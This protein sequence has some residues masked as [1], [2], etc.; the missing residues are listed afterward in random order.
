MVQKVGGCACPPKGRTDAGSA[1]GKWE[2]AR[3]K[4]FLTSHCELQ[5]PRLL[6]SSS[7]RKALYL[8]GN[9]G[10][11][12]WELTH[13]HHILGE[14]KTTTN[15]K[16]PHVSVFVWMQNWLVVIKALKNIRNTQHM[17][18][19]RRL[20]HTLRERKWEQ[21][22]N[23]WNKREGR[24]TLWMVKQC[25]FVLGWVARRLRRMRSLKVNIT[26]KAMSID[27]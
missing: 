6:I 18:P 23:I 7:K 25:H 15:Q 20:S 12:V 3:V 13:G 10:K 14:C 22:R 17:L 5:S 4:G 27:L 9:M 11:Q 24:L 21:G 26:L 8:H 19:S 16:Q 2:A 1:E